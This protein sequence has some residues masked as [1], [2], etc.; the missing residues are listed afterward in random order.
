MN[1]RREP[2]LAW[3]GWRHLGLTLVLAAGLNVWWVLVYG[4]ANW[5]TER[6]SYRVRLHL[7]AEL[8][9]P[10]VSAAVLGYMS[11]YPLLWSAPF[12][13]RT[14]RELERFAATLA[15]VMLIAGVCFLAF[16]ADS[17]FPTL[18]DMGRWGGL[19]RFA[20]DLAL[21]HNMAPSLH[22][23]LSVVCITVYARR[24]SRAGACLLWG[25]S[26][27]VA[28]STVLLHQHYLID[29]VTGY[30]LG[31]G[32]VRAVFDRRPTPR[33]GAPEKLPAS[34]TSCPVKSA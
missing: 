1:N 34:L 3:P 8:G 4:G 2:L 6:H 32:G 28:A 10:F 20:K 17:V 18:P 5:I 9:A 16:P 7:D 33:Q 21:A 19:V 26:V 12:V 29:V 11:I 31:W 13:L 14:R 27:V 24:A 22:V 23:A 25:W 30:A 15:V